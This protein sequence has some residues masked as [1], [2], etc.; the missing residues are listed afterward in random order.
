MKRIHERGG[1]RGYGRA[2]NHK[3]EDF[4]AALKKI[5][6]TMMMIGPTDLLLFALIWTSEEEE[7]EASP[8][9][10]TP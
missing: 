10:I 3:M 6:R 8:I 2:S 9:I 4:L 1:G 5:T 7:N